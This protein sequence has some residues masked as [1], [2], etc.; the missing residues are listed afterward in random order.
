MLSDP[1]P[2]SHRLIYSCAEKRKYVLRTEV[3]RATLR[4]RLADYS[5]IL[6]PVQFP[7]GVPLY[8]S[9]SLA[10]PESE[11]ELGGVL[12]EAVEWVS[13]SGED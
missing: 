1:F 3:L 7:T 4:G 6:G 9:V 11:L 2:Q 13:F 5:F 12:A 8:R 10:V